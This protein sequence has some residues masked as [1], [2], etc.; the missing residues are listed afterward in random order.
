MQRISCFRSTAHRPSRCCELRVAARPAIDPIGHHNQ[1]HPLLV[2]TVLIAAKAAHRPS[3]QFSNWQ[4]TIYKRV[5]PAT[6]IRQRRMTGI[7]TQ[8]MVQRGKYL[9][10]MNGPVLRMLS[11]TICRT[12][13]LPDF[14]A[15]TSEQH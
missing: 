9:S 11:E 12:D 10:K 4:P 15:T 7:D 13:N 1:D 8:L 3:N 5:R 14:H 6:Q 2:T